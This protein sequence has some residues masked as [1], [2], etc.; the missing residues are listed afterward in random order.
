[1]SSTKFIAVLPQPTQIGDKIRISGIVSQNAEQFSIN[2]A[3]EPYEHPQSITYHFKWDIA[4][5]IIIEDYKENGQW[6]DYKETY[7]AEFD[8]RSKNLIL[9]TNKANSHSL[10]E[11]FANNSSAINKT[12]ISINANSYFLLGP[13]FDLEFSFQDDGIYVYLVL[14][15]NRNNLAMFQS[16]N[17]YQYIQSIQ[18]WGDVNKI[19]QL[20][21]TYN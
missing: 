8:G 15:D 7:L 18:V 12:D 14:D 13:E 21:F 4:N 5:K 9:P 16:K 17:D 3:N 10:S 6:I 19:S 2:F 11:G 1:M 20:S